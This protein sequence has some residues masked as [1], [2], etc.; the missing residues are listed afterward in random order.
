MMIH[1]MIQPLF[2][3]ELICKAELPSDDSPE[4]LSQIFQ[5]KIN[6][7]QIIHLVRVLI[8]LEYGG[9][10]RGNA[11]YHSHGVQGTVGVTWIL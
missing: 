10:L 3:F 7:K 8:S 11:A 6:D 4:F 2:L 9:G 5:E 1:V